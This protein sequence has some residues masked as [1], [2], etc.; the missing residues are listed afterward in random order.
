MNEK[1][2]PPATY[3][4]EENALTVHIDSDAEPVPFV[5]WDPDKP[6][7]NAT[8]LSKL[9]KPMRV[10]LEPGDMLYLPAMW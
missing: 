2:I 6:A 10:T 8:A 4:R 1:L 5:T 3:R 9:A 7:V